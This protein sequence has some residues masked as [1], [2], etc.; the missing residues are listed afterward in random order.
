MEMNELKEKMDQVCVI[1]R[2][3]SA[4]SLTAMAINRQQT[5]DDTH[6]RT[7]AMVSP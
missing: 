2:W 7:V 3:F 6:F 1:N 4:L 5:V